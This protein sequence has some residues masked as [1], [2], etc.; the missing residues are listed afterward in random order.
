MAAWLALIVAVSPSSAA[1]HGAIPGIE[2]F[3]KGLLHPLGTASQILAILGLGVLVGQGGKQTVQFG[4]AAFAAA[5]LVGIVLRQIGLAH[6]ATD[7][8]LLAVAIGAAG[9]AALYPMVPRAV[10]MMLAALGGTMI[11]LASTPVSGPTGAAIVVLPGSLL[12]ACLGM[13]YIGGGVYWLNEEPRKPW[14]A[15]GIR[16]GAAWIATIATLLL[17]LAF[18]EMPTT[19]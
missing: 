7:L 1:A 17:A 12:G 5:C 4:V 13:F 14:R 10:P 15:I 19:A 3:Y 8:A 16:I 6:P 2:G 11:G 9:L 18:S